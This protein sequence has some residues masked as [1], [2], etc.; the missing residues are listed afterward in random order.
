[1]RRLRIVIPAVILGMAAILV[2][3]TFFHP[4]INTP[5]PIDPGKVSISGTKVTM[6]LP[7]VT[8]YTSDQRPYELTADTAVQDLAR[9]DVLDLH[10]LRAKV[11]LKDGQHVNLNSVAGVYDTKAEVLKLN[12]HIVITSSSGYEGHLTE[13]TVLTSKGVVTSEMPVDLKLP[14]NGFLHAKRLEIRD[15]GD[16]IRFY[17]G[18]ELTLNNP[19][20]QMHPQDP[21]PQDARPK[22][23]Q[24]R[25]GQPK[26]GHPQ[27]GHP[28]EAA[29][30]ARNNLREPAAEETE[31]AQEPIYPLFAQPVIPPVMF[32]P[33]Q[34][35][36]APAP[37]APG[38]RTPLPP[39][40]APS[41]Q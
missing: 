5:F 18:I 15:N 11:E 12:E 16:F 29:P 6:E 35:A 3:L 20:Q 27:N 19:D 13:A 1:M 34:A 9:L 39:R 28:Q 2:V 41:P 26:D 37:T 30:V 17:G 25:D 4:T 33:A 38:Q 23:G 21:H 14:N 36:P 7:R 40:R 32:P 8:G 24:P 22:D 10:T 31:L